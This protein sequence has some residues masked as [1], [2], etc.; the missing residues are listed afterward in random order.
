MKTAEYM[1]AAMKALVK[2]FPD[3]G[4]TLLIF[5]QAGPDKGRTN[6][7]SNCDRADMLAAMKEVAARFEGRAHN[8][9]ETKQ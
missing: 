8:A 1:Q 2:A 6:Y 5:P 4:I 9:P 7:V 3:C